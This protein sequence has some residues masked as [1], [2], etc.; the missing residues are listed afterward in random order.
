[1][2]LLLYV[3]ILIADYFLLINTTDEI[4]FVGNSFV[5]LIINYIMFVFD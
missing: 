5:K 1:M 2:R 3:F 4:N